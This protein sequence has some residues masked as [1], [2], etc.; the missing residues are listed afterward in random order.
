MGGFTSCDPQTREIERNMGDQQ[1]QEKQHKKLLLLGSGSSGKSTL[2]KQ[3]KRIHG[4]AVQDKEVGEAR[5]VIR[6]NIIQGVLHLVAQATKLSEEN[7]EHFGDCK[8]N[9]QEEQ[10]ASATQLLLQGHSGQDSDSSN[11]LVPV[12]N[13]I[14]FL[15]NLPG[16]QNIFKRREKLFSFPDNMDYFF[17]KCNEIMKTTYVP[18]DEDILKIRIRTTG[19]INYQYNVDPFT[20]VTIIDVGGQRNERK[21]WIHSFDAVTAIIYVAALNHYATVLF[22][23]EQKNAMH[24]AIELFYEI[25]NSKYFKKTDIILFLNKKDLFEECFK[26]ISLSFCFSHE[27]N[28]PGT[29]WDGMDYHPIPNNTEEDQKNFEVCCNHAIAFIQHSFTDQAQTAE[30]KKK[31]TSSYYMCN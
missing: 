21:K 17:N 11:E 14:H 28:W 25:R 7:V 3:I 9:M 31:N 6:I 19:V 22:E 13:A 16:V 8:V 18:N 5:H 4:I 2:F 30:G 15:W 27:K 20:T 1:L 26:K 10:V 24:E 12:G 23:D 29:P